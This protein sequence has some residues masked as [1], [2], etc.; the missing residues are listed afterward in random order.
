MKKY[1]I[2][3]ITGALLAVSAMMFMGS[4]NNDVEQDMIDEVQFNLDELDRNVSIRFS[5]VETDIADLEDD[6]NRNRRKTNQI[7]SEIQYAT[8]PKG[9]VAEVGRYQAFADEGHE[10][11]ID[12]QSAKT[13][14][15]NINRSRWEV[16][17]DGF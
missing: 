3:L 9:A 14:S 7:L 16:S 1:T 11:L 2:G 5:D 15:Y 8:T 4:Q 12:T 17:N 13:Y 6:F 10:Y